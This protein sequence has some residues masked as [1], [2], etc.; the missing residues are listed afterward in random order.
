[1]MLHHEPPLME[2]DEATVKYNG[3]AALTDITLSIHKGEKIALIGQSGAGKSTLLQLLYEQNKSDAAI[4][5]QELGLVRSLSVFHNIFMG[6]LHLNSTWYNL[7]NLIKPLKVEIDQIRPIVEKLRL[8]DKLFAPAGEL[9]GGQQQRTAV[10]RALHKNS[11]LFFGDEPVS[12][13]D[14]HQSH[15]VMQSIVDNHETVVLSMHD[16]K[17][18]IEYS[19]RVIGLKQGRMVMDESSNGMKASDLAG[20]YQ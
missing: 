13:V 3:Q 17:L 9:S 7:I 18:A 11:N 14:E 5:P 15:A 20:I 8:E 2:L 4:V 16:I 10:G 12:A 1:M 6:R 19:D